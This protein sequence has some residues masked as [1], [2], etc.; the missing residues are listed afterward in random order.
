MSNRLRALFVAGLIFA[1]SLFA[2][3]TIARI[4]RILIFEDGNLVYVSVSETL[5]YFSIN[6]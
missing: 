4:E 1:P 6:S 2:S 3:S 5:S